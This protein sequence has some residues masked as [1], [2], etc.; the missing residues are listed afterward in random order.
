MK[1]ENFQFNNERESNSICLVYNSRLCVLCKT[2]LYLR[3]VTVYYI[4]VLY[5][6]IP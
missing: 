2:I 4:I 1:C 3:D 6:N 5:I